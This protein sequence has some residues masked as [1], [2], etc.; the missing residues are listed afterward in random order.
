MFAITVPKDFGTQEA[1][2]DASSPTARRPRSSFW[3]NP[4]YW[5]DFFKNT[6]NENEPPG[7]KFAMDGPDYMGPPS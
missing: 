6:A 3:M 2:V 7:I 4:P 1:D 5:I